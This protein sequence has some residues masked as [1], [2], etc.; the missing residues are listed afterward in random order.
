MKI[1]LLSNTKNKGTNNTEINITINENL[2]QRR[3]I[4]DKKNFSSFDLYEIGLN[5][6]NPTKNGP[7]KI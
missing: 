1:E 2:I 7:N 3:D 4:E 5:L 6:E